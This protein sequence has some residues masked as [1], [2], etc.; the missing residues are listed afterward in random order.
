DLPTNTRK[1][2]VIP[3]FAIARNWNV[4]LLDE[5][6]KVRGEQLLQPRRTM[7]NNLPL[8]AALSRTVGGIPVL[9][10][11]PAWMA[12]DSKYAVAR[13]QTALFPDNP[14][15]LEGIDTLYVS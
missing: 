5:R 14:L 4:R 15:G 8:L 12:D 2:I 9:P 11:S 6:G 1:R 10:E 13:L 7:R 3:V